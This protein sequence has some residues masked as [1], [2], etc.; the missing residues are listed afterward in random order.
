MTYLFSVFFSSSF[1][2][3]VSFLCDQA[4]HPDLYIPLHEAWTTLYPPKLSG[5]SEFD[6]DDEPQDDNNNNR[7]DRDDSESGGGYV[8]PAV[9]TG[10]PIKGG[11]WD[12]SY[13]SLPTA[14]RDEIDSPSG[15]DGGGGGGGSGYTNAIGKALFSAAA[16]NSN[17]VQ[18]VTSRIIS[19]AAANPAATA[20]LAATVVSARVVKL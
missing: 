8:P 10:V 7:K 17:V 2:V 20:D 6:S 9:S 19:T 12:W 16:S 11:H 4:S 18:A 3:F 5:N 15:G 14:E 1:F 13:S